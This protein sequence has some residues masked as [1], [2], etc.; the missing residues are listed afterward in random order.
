MISEG[1]VRALAD[2]HIQATVANTAALDGL[3]MQI[4]RLVDVIERV[5]SG[6]GAAS[7]GEAVL[8]RLFGGGEEPKRRQGR[9]R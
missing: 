3:A 6:V 8:G 2:R 4:S 1:E 5:S 9:R 7:L